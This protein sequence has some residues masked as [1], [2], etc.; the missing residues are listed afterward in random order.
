MTSAKA[1][2]TCQRLGRC[3]YV[4]GCRA[5]SGRNSATIWRCPN[6]PELELQASP[7]PLTTSPQPRPKGTFRTPLESQ[8]RKQG[9]TGLTSAPGLTQRNCQRLSGACCLSASVTGG[10][11]PDPAPTGSR[12][13]KRPEPEVGV[14]G[15]CRPW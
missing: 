7:Q 13:D 2:H 15:R 1:L 8:R 5:W 14:G 3:Y 9:I 10:P 11:S 12:E 6:S 4:R